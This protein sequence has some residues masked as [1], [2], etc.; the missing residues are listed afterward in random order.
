MTMRCLTRSQGW[1]TAFD[2]AALL[3]HTNRFFDFLT[4]KMY[5]NGLPQ[6][7]F[8]RLKNKAQITSATQMHEYLVKDR[9]LKQAAT[10]RAP[11]VP[12]AAAGVAP[13]EEGDI[14]LD[15]QAI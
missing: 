1:Y 15:I 14:T 12:A 7:D 2:N 5:I 9:A 4:A 3:G 11:K 10:K 6:S 13:I 8:D